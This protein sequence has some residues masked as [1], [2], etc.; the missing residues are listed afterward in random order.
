MWEKGSSNDKVVHDAKV[1]QSLSTL[2]A[3]AT[4]VPY[5]G[6]VAVHVVTGNL[7][8]QVSHDNGED[9][10]RYCNCFCLELLVEGIL[11][12]FSP[13]FAGA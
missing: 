7:G 11:V 6:P 13:S 10:V 3:G 2:I 12:R 9:M 8:I 5:Y 1:N 4:S